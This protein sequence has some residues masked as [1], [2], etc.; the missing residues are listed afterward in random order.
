MLFQNAIFNFVLL[1]SILRSSNENALRWMPLDLT[2]DKP[3]LVRVMAWCRQAT[4]HYLSQ[5][6]ARFMLLYGIIRPQWLNHLV[7]SSFFFFVPTCLF[8]SLAEREMTSWYVFP[9]IAINMLSSRIGT[10][11][12]NTPNTNLVSSGWRVWSKSSYWKE[13]LWQTLVMLA[14]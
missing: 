4:S 7:S 10:S 1:L 13:N 8:H 5:Y 12:A 11:T 14:K 3:T 9:I 6:W 2:D